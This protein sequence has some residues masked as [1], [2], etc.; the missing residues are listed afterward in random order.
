ME[1]RR[2]RG[3]SEPVSE[4]HSDCP[5]GNNAPFEECCGRF[6]EGV[7][8]D[9]AEALMRSRYTAYAR[10][11]FDHIAATWHPKT[12]PKGLLAELNASTVSWLGLQVL[13]V[14]QGQPSD[15]IGKVTFRVH[16]VE[17]GQTLTA[18]ERSRFVRHAGR[19]AYLDGVR[20]A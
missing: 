3:L 13:D 18:Q 2:R 6:I 7:A 8:P 1:L 10:R 11:A 4:F 9:T 5:C 19:W 20:D 15:K 14:R 12:R 17:D 16:Y